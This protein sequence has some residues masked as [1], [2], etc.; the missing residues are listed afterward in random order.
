MTEWLLVRSH[1]SPQQVWKFRCGFFPP[2]SLSHWFSTEFNFTLN[3]FFCLI[4]CLFW[5]FYCGKIH[6]TRASL[7]AQTVKNLRQC[8][9]PGLDPWVRKIPW[10]RAWQPTPVLLPGESHGQRSLVCCSPWG[11]KES[12][13]FECTGVHTHTHACSHFRT[14]MWDTGSKLILTKGP[15]EKHRRFQP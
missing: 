3:L 4:I 13:M 1:D 10:R 6:I 11:H 2:V 8:G 15:K 9:R 14:P 12:D 7:V 5:S